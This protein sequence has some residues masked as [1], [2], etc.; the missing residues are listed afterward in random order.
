[1]RHCAWC[2]DLY[3]EQD[4]TS[5]EPDV[6]CCQAHGDAD[7]QVFINQAWERAR[8]MHRP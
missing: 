6:Y 3:V 4:S 5:D 7:Y 8:D 2:G 1:M